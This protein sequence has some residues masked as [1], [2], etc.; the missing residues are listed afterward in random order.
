MEPK[1]SQLE[2]AGRFINKAPAI[3]CNPQIQTLRLSTEVQWM[4][5]DMLA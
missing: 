4:A 1:V 3:N 5:L 2:R